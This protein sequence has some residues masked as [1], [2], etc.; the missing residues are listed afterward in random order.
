MG[1]DA[2]MP[3]EGEEAGRVRKAPGGGEVG[4]QVW[5]EHPWRTVLNLP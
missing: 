1:K 2:K 3:G 4:E 5:I